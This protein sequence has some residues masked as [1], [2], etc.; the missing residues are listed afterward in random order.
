M[1]GDQ[2]FC[3]N[4][5]TG[6]DPLSMISNEKTHILICTRHSE[7][8]DLKLLDNIEDMFTLYYSHIDVFRWLKSSYP[9]QKD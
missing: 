1:F 9:S 6:H 3:D 4:G 7:A 2:C 8:N 5:H